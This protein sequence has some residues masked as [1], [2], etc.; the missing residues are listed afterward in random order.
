MR[1]LCIFS[2]HT[3]EETTRFLYK[4]PVVFGSIPNWLNNKKLVI[5]FFFIDFG[6]ERGESG[7]WWWKLRNCALDPIRIRICVRVL[8]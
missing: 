4:K 2:A 5:I 7:G 8:V 3:E 6:Y 1:I